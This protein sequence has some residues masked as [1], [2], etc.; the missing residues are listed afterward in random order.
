MAYFYSEPSILQPPAV[1]ILSDEE[2]EA[3]ELGLE[4]SRGPLQEAIPGL[5]EAHCALSQLFYEIMTYNSTTTLPPNSAECLSA[6]GSFFAR[7]KS[8]RTSLPQNLDPDKH[9]TVHTCY[10]Q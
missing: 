5:F 8:F 6:R 10:L 2:A 7:L 4:A 1:P 9:F 3:K